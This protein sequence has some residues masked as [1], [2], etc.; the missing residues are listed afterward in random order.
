MLARRP[1][2]GKFFRGRVIPSVYGEL[3][4]LSHEK[5]I[6][7]THIH[8]YTNYT[9]GCNSLAIALVQ[10]GH[11]QELAYVPL[12]IRI[13]LCSISMHKNYAHVHN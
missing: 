4:L 2:V 1:E 8:V 6:T 9:E 7:R 11:R 3:W 5:R 10:K 12:Q 13:D